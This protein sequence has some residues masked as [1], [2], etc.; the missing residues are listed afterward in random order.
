MVS[1]GSKGPEEV[2]VE[3]VAP[4]FTSASLRVATEEDVGVASSPSSSSSSPS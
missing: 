1:E 3:E 2:E 4:T